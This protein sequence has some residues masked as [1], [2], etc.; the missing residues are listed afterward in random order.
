M[1]E[2]N[3]LTHQ[4]ISLGSLYQSDIPITESFHTLV[5]TSVSHE[6]P[7]VDIRHDSG[8]FSTDNHTLIDDNRHVSLY[9]NDDS[10]IVKEKN[11]IDLYID[12]FNIRYHKP[13]NVTEQELLHDC[14]RPAT[15]LLSRFHQK[16]VLHGN[17]VLLNGKAIVLVAPSG[18]GK[19]TMCLAL[20]RFASLPI[21]SDDEIMLSVKTPGYLFTGFPTT[22]IRA[23]TYSFFEKDI[24]PYIT[25]TCE[26]KWCYSEV[27]TTPDK[28]L[29][30]QYPIG[31]F[32]FLKRA[33]PN[34][35]TPIQFRSITKSELFIQL[36]KNMKRM[37][38]IKPSDNAKALS[39][40]KELSD[41]I[42]AIE[43]T[44]QHGFDLLDH[45]VTAIVNT[46]S[47][48]IARGN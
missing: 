1:L 37:P 21:L 32:V 41:S 28:F 46:L 33:E 23:K 39:L 22:W 5:N 12:A 27:L 8:D 13:Q 9:I 36:M 35:I 2:N 40:S 48:V 3:K 34:C 10:I 47:S 19:S 29:S 38:L 26:D 17:A 44:L 15:I 6:L 16:S 31:A 20:H 42:P 45:Q 25:M 43:I 4:I 24:A 30:P 18:C 11:G 14:F 7:H